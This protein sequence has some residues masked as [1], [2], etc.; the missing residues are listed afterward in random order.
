M[1]INVL[2]VIGLVIVVVFAVLGFVWDFEQGWM[3][4]IVGASAGLALVVS[5]GIEKQ[6]TGSKWKGYL[7]G[8]G[9][10]AGAM[11]AVIGGVQESIL[12]TIIGAVILI[13]TVIIGVIKGQQ[14]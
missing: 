14:E 13:A 12:A 10:S 3:I 11:I 6:G 1:K 9:L 2:A 5:A 4:E 8:L 7:I